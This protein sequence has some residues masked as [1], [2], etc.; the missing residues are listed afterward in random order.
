MNLVKCENG[1]F[2][3][4]NRY[5]QCPHC[6]G[7]GVRNDNMTV[8][9]MHSAGGDA[10]TTVL[11]NAAPADLTAPLTAPPA[12][13]PAASTGVSLQE[14]VRS[15]AGGASPPVTGGGDEM[16]VS[17]YKRAIGT[18]PVVGWLVC[19]AGAHFGEDFRLKSGRNFIGRAADMDVVIS[20]DSAVSRDKHA[21]VVYEPKGN[22]FLVMSGESR[23]LCYID[24]DVV[25]SPRE[26]NINDMLTVGDTTLMFIPCCSPEFNWDSVKKE[27][28]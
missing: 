9:V 8:P 25:L 21:V 11:S 24:N 2:Y 18:E 4:T 5:D 1:H 17:F 15:A 20:K 10:V 13:P 6:T 7:G 23:E 19:V 12:A 26:L 22:T 14:A 27:E 3:D 28:K 16:T